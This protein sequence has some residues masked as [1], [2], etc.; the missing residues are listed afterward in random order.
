MVYKKLL[1]VYSHEGGVGKTLIA[2]NLADM[3]ARQ[4]ANV[5]LMDWD[6][7]GQAA[8]ALGLPVRSGLSEWLVATDRLAHRPY[9]SATGTKNL[10]L[11]PS[12]PSLRGAIQFIAN[13]VAKADLAPTYLQ[14]KMQGLVTST[15]YDYIVCDTTPVHRDRVPDKILAIHPGTVVIPVAMDH[16]DLTKV[17]AA[18][19][20]VQDWTPEAQVILLPTFFHP[21]WKITVANLQ[22]WQAAYPGIVMEAIP[23][24]PQLRVAQSTGLTVYEQDPRSNRLPRFT[25]LVRW[26]QREAD[27]ILLGS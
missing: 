27:E 21:R 6:E 5:L 26:I 15:A 24:R 14:D 1:V 17:Q 4:G 18:Y 20:T 3:L 9:L 23:Y 7:R 25:Q 10:A 11:L 19:E 12:D 22:Q 8:Q 13:G 2:V 16:M